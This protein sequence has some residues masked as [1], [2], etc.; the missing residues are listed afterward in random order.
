MNPPITTILM[1]S[2]NPQGSS[3]QRLDQEKRDIYEGL[4]RSRWRDRF[5]LETHSAVRPRDLQRAMLDLNPQIVHFSGQG[6]AEAGLVF[7]D[8]IG[9]P[10]RIDPEALADLFAL[11]ADLQ[12][13]VLNA[14]YSEA[15]AEAIAQ[16]IPYV[17]GMSAAIDDRAAIEFAVGFYDALGA[18]KDFESAYQFGRS[19]ARLAGGSEHLFPI[20]KQKSGSDSVPLP[21]APTEPQKQAAPLN[22]S[23]LQPLKSEI[24]HEPSNSINLPPKTERVNKFKP[25]LNHLTITG[26]T[27][28]LLIGATVVNLYMQDRQDLKMGD[29]TCFEQA[30]K[31]KKLVVAIA[32]FQQSATKDEKLPFLQNQIFDYLKTQNRVDVEI[33]SIPAEVS[34]EEAAKSLG[35]KSNASII[36]W[37][38]QDSSSIELKVTTINILVSNLTTLLIPLTDAQEP[39]GIKDITVDINIMTAFAL[40]KI[41]E[42]VETRHLETQQILEEALRFAELA[43]LN[44]NKKFTARILS[45]GYY[46]LGQLYVSHDKNCSDYKRDCMKA[47]SAFKKATDINPSFYQ[48]FAEQAFIEQGILLE[49]IN[50]DEAIKAYTQLIQLNPRSE[51]GIIAR[52]NRADIYIKKGNLKQAMEDLQIVCQDPRNPYYWYWLSLRG[53]VELLTGQIEKA[54]STFREVKS[55]VDIEKDLPKVLEDLNHLAQQRQSLKPTIQSIIQLIQKPYQE[56]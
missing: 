17:V 26:L 44:L 50:I 35:Q 56:P 23:I 20:L 39:E 46:F 7:E 11:F 24:V 16:H 2:A 37:G 51:K 19:A 38:R 12:C 29:P 15:Q 55:S 21:P 53:K 30:A 27:V 25:S 3:A 31:E 43:N 47:L 10:K 41:Y 33:C 13:V 49:Q 32:Q 1:L 14:C 9:Q 5:Q 40:S 18:G 4:K 22:H 6:E 52:G 48:S 8:A 34:N 36:I 45:Q 54:K 28:V 42:Q